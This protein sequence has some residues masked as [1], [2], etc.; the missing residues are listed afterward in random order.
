MPENSLGRAL[1]NPF[2]KKWAEFVERLGPHNERLITELTDNWHILQAILEGQL[3]ARAKISVPDL[4]PSDLG[5]FRKVRCQ[6]SRMLLHEPAGEVQRRRP[7]R[8]ALMAVET[9]K[10]SLESL[11]RS[12]PMT[13]ALSGA[14][15]DAVMDARISKGLMRK[16]VRRRRREHTLPLRA[17]IAAELQRMSAAWAEIEARYFLAL[18]L[19]QRHLR[20]PWEATRAAIDTAVLGRPAL[21][22]VRSEA[23]EQELRAL[24]RQ[25]KQALSDLR[26]LLETVADQV[27]EGILAEL[28][29][30]AGWEGRTNRLQAAVGTAHWDMQAR[31]AE[32]EI[33]LEQSL[34]ICEDGILGLVRQGLDGAQEE[35]GDLYAEIDGA[36]EW[37]RARVSSVPEDEFPQP[38]A[39]IVPASSRMAELESLLR[40]E[41]E[42]L[43]R[44]CEA[45]PNFS[46]QPHRR[47]KFRQLRPLEIVQQA[48]LRR[49]RLEILSLL[50]EI[51]SEHRA[52][53]QQIGRA[54]AVVAFARETAG[55]GPES[56]PHVVQEALQN[57]ISLL[58]FYRV[59]QPEWC[60][61]AEPRLTR[62]L[63]SVFIEE[64]LILGLHR[65]GVFTYLA[66]Q[67]LCRAVI[68]VGRRVTA[69]LGFALRRT[70]DILESAIVEVLVRIGWKPAPSADRVE[71]VTRPY[72]PEE[73]TVDLSKKDLPAL[74]R[75]LFRF[76]PVM[77][78][79]FLV[80]R[81]TE[82][83]GIAAARSMW[84]AGRPV[85]VILVG[86]RGSGKTSLINCALKRTLAGLEV[87]RSEFNQRLMIEAEMRGFLTSLIEA[88]DQAQLEISLNSR[89]RIVILEELER[90]F[91]RQ[92]G[93]YGAIRGL[94]R[95]IAATSF[96][97][98][99]ILTTNQTAFQFLDAAVKLGQSFSHRINAGTASRGDLSR[100]IL[101][102]HNLSG[103][104]IKFAAPPEQAGRVQML[105]RSLTDRATPDTIFFDVLSRESAGVYR[106]AFEIW[107][108]QIDGVQNGTLYMKPLSPPD[109]SG[110]VDRLTLED[111]FTLVAIPQ[112]GGLTAEEHAVV[113]QK[114]VAASRA[115]LNE[116]LADEIIE[117]DPAHPGF[118]I[119]PEAMRVVREALYR[120]NL[121]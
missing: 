108:G 89:R 5:S 54:R 32:T 2:S 79:R 47:A 4:Q 68:L 58:D 46:A 102:R 18:A 50:Q 56:D 13:V 75:R 36:L 92:V 110:V 10:E 76:E 103:L 66:Q 67:G 12:L 34:E 27:G 49:G 99:W 25:A 52:I 1:I 20:R 81:E 72:L 106:S 16:W 60:A 86:Q 45:L 15:A 28:L 98:L 42:K 23:I 64:R 88:D 82:M 70:F 69:A 120:R 6:A 90:T 44:T 91:L 51:E 77:D 24:I 97:T 80:G 101:L 31:D 105:R 53:V 62:A 29:L 87:V 26:A 119:R 109:L 100:A 55:S 35:L 17:V 118:R 48:F 57:A 74:Y 63:A 40:P 116:L 9:Y 21:G 43:P 22:Q 38:K 3:G 121:L 111:L 95:V 94:L 71:V 93:Y 114:S 33:Q 65:F 61:A 117:A 112:H 73:F 39:D 14:Q 96:S 113:F 11:I 8:R 104:R 30:R 115:Q 41:L 107:L 78:P 85:A 7:Y 37:L 83:D 59:E 84:E 19:A